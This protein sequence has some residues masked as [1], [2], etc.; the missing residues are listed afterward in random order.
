MST[1]FPTLHI[2]KPAIPGS[3]LAA[4]PH[5]PVPSRAWGSPTRSSQHCSAPWSRESARGC[6]FKFKKEQASGRASARERA[7]G[8]WERARTAALLHSA[9][10]PHGAPIS[11]ARR[12]QQE[13]SAR[14]HCR[15]GVAAGAGR[16]CKPTAGGRRGSRGRTR[17]RTRV[18]FAE[19]GV[20]RHP[21]PHTERGRHKRPGYGRTDAL[22]P[23]FYARNPGPLTLCASAP[24]RSAGTPTRGTEH[25]R[26]PSRAQPLRALRIAWR[27]LARPP[28]AHTRF[29]RLFTHLP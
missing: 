27:Q 12:L 17:S 11:E 1:G 22:S 18:P 3:N 28:C 5:P 9:A 10:G 29:T 19:P 6:H 15:G 4:P 23:S 26:H 24:P 25:A 14:L 2:H 7:A 13:T 20:S 16:P 21:G 8:S